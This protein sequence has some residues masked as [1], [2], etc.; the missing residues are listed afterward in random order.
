MLKILWYRIQRLLTAV[1]AAVLVAG[2][3]TIGGVIVAGG[4]FFLASEPV[5]VPPWVIGALVGGLVLMGLNAWAEYKQRTYD[6][7]LA[8]RF[9]EKFWSE[10]IISK[11]K[12][13]AD[14]LLNQT[15]NLRRIERDL[16][17]VDD[18]LDFLEDL[19]FFQHGHQVSPEIMHHLFYHWIRGYYIATR[20]RIYAWQREEPARWCHIKELYEMTDCIEGRFDKGKKELSQD[21]IKTFLE[22][23]RDL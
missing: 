16:I 20:D 12:K 7:S 15:G 10:A 4:A 19:G 2:G 1:S 14:T 13:A 5:T 21:Q 11:R 18:I 17:A 6:P 8:M 23:E 3:A 9:D 22:E